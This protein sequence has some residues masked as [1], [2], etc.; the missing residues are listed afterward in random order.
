MN[1]PSFISI[2]TSLI[3][4]A[5]LGAFATQK[6]YKNTILGDYT[7][8]ELDY[9]EDDDDLIN[10]DYVLMVQG[11]NNRGKEV[12]KVID[13]KDPNKSD[14]PR[15]LNSVKR[16]DGKKENCKFFINGNKISVKTIRDIEIGEELLVNYGDEYF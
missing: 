11:Y 5:G 13:A 4:D 16:G 12:F 9:E 8:E 14:W 15:Y 1:I 7:G 10:G 2:R 3:P 6:L